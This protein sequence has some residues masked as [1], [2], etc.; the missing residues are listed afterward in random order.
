LARFFLTLRKLTFRMPRQ[1]NIIAAFALLVVFGLAGCESF[2]SAGAGAFSTVVVD[3]GHGGHDFGGRAVFGR[4]EKDLALDTALRLKRALEWRGLRVIITRN[5]DY[6]ITL[7]QRIAVSNRTYGSIFVSIHYNWDRGRS[8]HGVETYFCSPRS[9][10]LA[11]NVQR[12]LA[13]AYRTSNRGVKR[14]C[15]IRVLRKNTRPAILVEGGFDSNPSENAVL[16]SANGRQR[17]ADAVARGILAERNGR[18][19]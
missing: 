15:W 13:G 7:D 10:R 9:F 3:P 5:A 12:E 16:Q 18:R 19:P 1:I 11:A 4:N 14:G 6:F 8:G 2:S 17:I